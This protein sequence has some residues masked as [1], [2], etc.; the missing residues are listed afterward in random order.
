MNARLAHLRTSPSAFRHL[1]GLTVG[2]FAP[3]AR[4]VVPLIGS[5]H[6]ATLDRPNRERAAGAGGEFA[7]GT[8]DPLL[9]TVV[10]VRQYPTQEVL[11]SLFG[12]SDSTA[13]RVV[14]RCLPVLGKAGRDTAR[15]PDPG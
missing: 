2:A 15:M 10:W 3:R 5:A 6:R 11:G 7:P 4:D 9:A 14:D 8:A 12:V 13:G 1:T